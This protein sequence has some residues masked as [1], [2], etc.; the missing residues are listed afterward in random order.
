MII[1]VYMSLNI[2]KKQVL[3]D[4]IL[5]IIAAALP[6]VVLQLIIFP[7]VA[8]KET[9]TIYGLM[10][11]I[12]A[13][14]MLIPNIC[15]NSICNVRLVKNSLYEREQLEGD[16][17][18]IVVKYGIINLVIGIII[19]A[20]YY[21]MK[22]PVGMCLSLIVILLTFLNAYYE[23]YF[24]IKLAFKNRLYL[25]VAL[26]AGY[27]AGMLLYFLLHRWEVVFLCGQICTSCFI[28]I[29]SNL[30]KEQFVK[31]SLFKGTDKDCLF[32][33]IAG[34]LA[35]S[36]DYTDRLILMPIAG[37]K[38][39]TIYYIAAVIGKL[40]VFI[41]PPIKTLLLSYISHIEQLSRK[42]MIF[43]IGGGVI[44]CIAMYLICIWISPYVLMILY[45][46]YLQRALTLVPIVT[47]AALISGFSSVV[48]VFVMRY[49]KMKWQ[50]IING[51]SVGAFFVSS[52]ILLHLYGIIGFCVGNVIGY[53]VKLCGMVIVLLLGYNKTKGM[54][55]Q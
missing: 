1:G 32:L 4:G 35:S 10:I 39:V 15:G 26:V 9:E 42:Q 43:I 52:L 31:T 51:F 23:V 33:I 21:R 53:L 3:I 37:A 11:T 47:I 50:L 40:I 48:Q 19:L 49:C 2:T 27:F 16:F 38:I 7:I 13:V 18:V 22:D 55:V 17:N 46:Q 30:Y 36:L 34:L 41:I 12:Y 28:L 14:F 5:N 29:K 45:P 44:L 25:R 20:Y 6:V 24:S 8:Q 54:K